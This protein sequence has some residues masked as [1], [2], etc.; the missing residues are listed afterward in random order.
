[1]S[2][3]IVLDVAVNGR[4]EMRGTSIKKMEKYDILPE[5]APDNELPSSKY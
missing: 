1:M 2:D 4:Q 3:S 5:H